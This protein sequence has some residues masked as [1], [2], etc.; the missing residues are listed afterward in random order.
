M[1]IQDLDWWGDGEDG[2]NDRNKHL[3]AYPR[4]EISTGGYGG[5]D[6]GSYANDSGCGKRNGGTAVYGDGIGR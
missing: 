2:I 3:G 5:G 4:R 6:L 1:C